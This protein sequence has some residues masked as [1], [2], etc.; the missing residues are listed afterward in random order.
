MCAWNCSPKRATPRCSTTGTPCR[1]MTRPR[2]RSTAI[3][4]R[5]L[6][7]ERGRRASGSD[8]LP[9]RTSQAT[10]EVPSVAK[11]EEAISH[12]N[13]V[14]VSGATP[15]DVAGQAAYT[16]RVSP[17][18]QGSLIGG[19][20]LSWDAANGV[21]LRA[22]IYSSTSSSPTIELAAT[23]IS[24][25]PGRGVGVRIHAAVE[26]EGRRNRA[27]REGRPQADRPR[28]IAAITLTSPPMARASRL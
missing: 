2:T 10:H 3:R 28:R 16:V 15:T 8:S 26:R 25:G 4:C 19:G 13:H 27:S 12:L 5:L 18:E 24:Y 20:E 21:P 1:S 14:N 9:H 23:S 6:R 17:K 7:G 11:I 22:A